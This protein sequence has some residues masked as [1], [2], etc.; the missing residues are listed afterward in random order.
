[1]S[2]RRTLLASAALLALLAASHRSVK[3]FLRKRLLRISHARLRQRATPWPERPSNPVTVIVAPHQDDCALGCGGLIASRRAAK[4]TVHIVYITDGAGSHPKHPKVTPAMLASIRAEE[5]RMAATVL[6]VP[7][8]FLTFLG[9]PDGRLPHLSGD[10][11]ARLVR[12][13]A[14]VLD[15]FRPSELF[16]TSPDD[17]SSEHAASHA[18]VTDALALLKAPAPRLF[19]YVVWAR[20]SPLRLRAVARNTRSVHRLGFDDFG[21]RKQRAIGVFKSQVDPI[22][23]WTEPALPD[24]FQK[25]FRTPEE[26]FF[27]R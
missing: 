21:E 4:E 22:P 5:A 20:W 1:M 8:R 12:S 26:F 2:T 14:N 15:E 19:E 16:V 23:P 27:E 11:R 24:N 17:G 13:L 7:N 9:A 25:M 6:G 18:L 3:L 10:E